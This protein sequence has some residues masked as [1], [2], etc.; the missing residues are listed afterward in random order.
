[1][2]PFYV[3]LQRG[4]GCWGSSDPWGVCGASNSQEPQP[5][6]AIIQ[7]Q[8]GESWDV[9]RDARPPCLLHNPSSYASSP[10]FYTSQT[11]QLH[12]KAQLNWCHSHT[13][14]LSPI[15]PIYLWR[16][17]LSC[18]EIS[19]FYAWQIW[20]FLKFL[21]MKGNFKSLYMTYVEKSKFSPHVE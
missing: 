7:T 18:G 3:S 15:P 11:L 10:I 12:T 21:H 19:D 2:Y 8:E 9:S 5:S 20:R 13:S 16:K 4:Q 17:K 1:M 14:Y 6:A